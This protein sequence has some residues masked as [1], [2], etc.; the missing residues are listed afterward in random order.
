MKISLDMLV[1]AL[2]LPLASQSITVP[3]HRRVFHG[4]LGLNSTNLHRAGVAVG[5]LPGFRERIAPNAVRDINNLLPAPMAIVGDYIHLEEHDPNLSTLD[6]HLPHILSSPGN[7]VWQIALLPS[8]G[9]EKVTPYVADRIAIKMASINKLGI[10]VWL[11][12]AHEMNGDW[13]GWG[14][15]PELFRQK[16]RM[17]AHAI[18]ART[19]GTYMLWAPNVAFGSYEDSIRGGYSRYWPGA[20][21]VDISGLSFYHFGGEDRLNVLPRPG[22]ALEKIQEFSQLYGAGQGKPIV[23]AET[24]AAYTTSLRTGR[25]TFGG[26]SNHDIKFAWLKQLLSGELKQRVPELKAISW[27]ELIKDENAGVQGT[28]VKCED[29]RLIVGEERLSRDAVRFLQGGYY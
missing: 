5:F 3:S 24:G 11:R 22:E 7:P 21:T 13:Y 18:R 16:W 25:P 20:D 28:N 27:F 12:F 17:L 15:K 8:E 19:H 26:A 2:L 29:Y 6:L 14:L 4:N 9:L 10:T 23:L 1:S